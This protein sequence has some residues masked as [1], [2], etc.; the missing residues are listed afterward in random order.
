MG[1]IV[2]IV[3]SIIEGMQYVFHLSGLYCAMTVLG[4]G[5]SLAGKVNVIILRFICEFI[6]SEEGFGNHGHNWFDCQ[7]NDKLVNRIQLSNDDKILQVTFIYKIS[8][9]AWSRN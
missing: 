8:I 2:D 3:V 9:G 7:S 4:L 5:N 1:Y 6:I